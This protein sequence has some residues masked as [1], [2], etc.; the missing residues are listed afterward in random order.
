M[1][2]SSAS[3]WDKGQRLAELVQSQKTLLLLD[4]MEPLQSY[5]E[6]EKGKIKDPALAVL[7]TELAKE[8]PGLCVITT[9][10]NVLDL[11]DYPE[12]TQQIDLEQISPEAGR[13]LLRVGGVQETVT[14][15][16][17]PIAVQFTSSSTIAIASFAALS[18]GTS[19]RGNRGTSPASA[20][21]PCTA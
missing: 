15:E 19:S 7:V 14:V 10:E 6:F 17:P 11:A 13:A 12:T 16:A 3:P 20:G 21:R 2:N 18:R 5:F 9:R 8:N 4:G 1:A